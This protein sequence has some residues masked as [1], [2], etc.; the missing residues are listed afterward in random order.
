MTPSM[1]KYLVLFVV[2]VGARAVY[3]ALRSNDGIVFN[4]G[5]AISSMLFLIKY[6][7]VF[8]YLG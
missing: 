5:I 2:F 1:I 7:S 3:K 4:L 6:L 8:A